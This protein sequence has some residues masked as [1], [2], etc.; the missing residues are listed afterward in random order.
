MA[1]AAHAL[2]VKM[3]KEAQSYKKPEA[4]AHDGLLVRGE[5]LQKTTE[6][7]SPWAG[8]AEE[9]AKEPSSNGDLGPNPLNP[10]H[11]TRPWHLS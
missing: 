4:I 8:F 6:L 5:I 1:L 10:K 7:A 2:G 9:A 3:D 11:L